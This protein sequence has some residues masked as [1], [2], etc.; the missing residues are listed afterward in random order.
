MTTGQTP[1]S[2]EQATEAFEQIRGRLT[3]VAYRML[4]SV[5]DAEDAVQDT[6]VK[7][8]G[9][10]HAIIEHPDAWLL[11][12]CTR[13]CIDMLRSAHKTRVDYVGTWLPEPVLGEPAETPGDTVELASSLTTAFL[14]VLERLS[15]V[16]RAAYL[17][18]EI[19]DYDYE[20]VAFVLDKSEQACRKTVSRARKRLGDKHVRQRPS[21][22][23][24]QKLL[25]EFLDALRS[26]DAKNLETVLARDA[27]LWADGGGK[28]PA[29]E[30]VIAGGTDVAG[31]LSMVW[32]SAWRH[33]Q[34]ERATVNGTAGFILRHDETVV[35]TVALSVDEGGRCRRLFIVRNP[36][37]LTHVDG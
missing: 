37:K 10:D 4:G 14:L 3:G 33:M 8:Q 12:A 22:D 28:V 5:A 2:I 20:D 1:M 31:F 18:R 9:V 35:G 11:S 24:Q 17:L 25:D 30:H 36:D 13:R 21:E 32:E 26:G 6:Y 19:F 29:A 34:I 15:P 16:E 27:E 7:W 23:M